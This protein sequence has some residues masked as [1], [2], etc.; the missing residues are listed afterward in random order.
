[1]FEEEEQRNE[2]ASKERE[3]QF[4]VGGQTNNATGIERPFPRNMPSF[5]A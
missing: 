5:I 1:M 3:A 4:D 2:D